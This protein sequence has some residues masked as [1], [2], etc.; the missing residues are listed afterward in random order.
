[1]GLHVPIA[2]SKLE[3]LATKRNRAFFLGHPVVTRAVDQENLNDQPL[4]TMPGF[5]L[6]WWFTGAET[7]LKEDFGD[8]ERNL[9]FN[10]L[11]SIIN[12]LGLQ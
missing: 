12:L 5:K 8:D 1:M 11:N 10:R 2:A 4:N 7:N 3:L 9:N 6:T